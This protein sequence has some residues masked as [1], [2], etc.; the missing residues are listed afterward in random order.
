MIKQR[1]NR[2][3]VVLILALTAISGLLY[4]Q[5]PRPVPAKTADSSPGPGAPCYRTNK[6]GL[7][8]SRASALF[9]GVAVPEGDAPAPVLGGSAGEV[10]PCAGAVEPG[11]TRATTPR[12]WLGEIQPTPEEAALIRT[13]LEPFEAWAKNFVALDTK[14]QQAQALERGK[15]QARERRDAL[16]QI[17]RTNPQLALQKALPY[18]LR[19]ELPTDVAGLLEERVSAKG[20]LGVLGILATADGRSAATTIRRIAEIDGKS[21]EAFVYGRRATQL[22]RENISLHGIALDGAVALS[23]SPVRVL[24]AGEPP[25]AGKQR[26]AESCPIS[27]QAVEA[28]SAGLAA[29]AQA[30]TAESGDTVYFLCSGGH[31]VQLADQLTGQEGTESPIMQSAWTTGNKTVLYIRVNYPDD[32]ADPQ[33]QASSQTMMNGCG[34]FFLANSYGVTSMTTT[35]GRR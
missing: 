35:V 14:E 2:A 29:S 32:L 34:A 1:S 10:C 3:V 20:K 24:D 18:L 5:Y 11:A 4:F 6:P 26:A 7:Q 22:T 28:S 12:V 16:K 25:T 15:Q 27:G 17:I 33:S 9:A 30:V 31:M 13:R 8:A 19:K 21:Y 23:E